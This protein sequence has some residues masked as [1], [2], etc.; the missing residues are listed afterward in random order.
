M[1]AMLK[2]LINITAEIYSTKY[3]QARAIFLAGSMVRGE[4]TSTSD[5]DL[6]VVFDRLPSAYRDSYS[7]GRWLIEA[8]VHDPQTLEYFFWEVDRPSGF[9]SLPAMVAEGVEVPTA[10][11]FTDSPKRL[12]NSVLNEGPPKWSEKDLDGSRYRITD[13]INDLRDPRSTQEMHATA[14]LLYPALAN[15]YFR[16]RNIWSA[17]GKAI[18]RRLHAVDSSFAKRF[19]DS[20]DSIFSKNCPEKVIDM[21]AEI[22]ETDGG[23]LFEGHRLEAPKSWRIE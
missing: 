13:L 18:P 8:F 11:E 9:P 7:Y 15:H 1:N 16:S 3:S 10:N 4:G 22:L 6:V 21:A 23:F 14:T 17:T 12:A 2:E 5:L 20:F 19:L